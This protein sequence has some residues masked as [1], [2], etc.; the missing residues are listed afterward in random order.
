M[1][2]TFP[3]VPDKLFNKLF[4]VAVSYKDNIF[5]VALNPLLKKK[6]AR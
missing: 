6:C 1:N 5:K 4:V 3:G 2:I